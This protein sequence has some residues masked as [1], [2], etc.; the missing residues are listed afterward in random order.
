MSRALLIAAVVY[1]VG[2]LVCMIITPPL[3]IWA[4]HEDE[5]EERGYIE[6]D[7]P[8][9]FSKALLASMLI[10]IIWFIFIPLYVLMLAE[11]IT[12]RDD[13]DE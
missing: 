9:L 3:I 13:K 11:K 2:Y 8:D 7:T 5:R 12:G 6:Q 1:L 4:I 10:S